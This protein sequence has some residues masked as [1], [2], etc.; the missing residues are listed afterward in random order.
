MADAGSFKGG[1]KEL[2][3]LSKSRGGKLAAAGLN[4]YLVYRREVDAYL[5]ICEY[6][7][8][9][10]IIDLYPVKESAACAGMHVV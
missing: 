10:F 5:I 3:R 6:D 9:L 4:D 8:L 2:L 7:R 1:E